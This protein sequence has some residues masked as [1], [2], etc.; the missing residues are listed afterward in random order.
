MKSQNG[1]HS[2]YVQDSYIQYL[3]T[4]TTLNGPTYKEISYQEIGWV[5]LPSPAR[6]WSLVAVPPPACWVESPPSTKIL[7]QFGGGPPS[8][9]A[10]H[11]SDGRYVHF[12]APVVIFNVSPCVFAMLLARCISNVFLVGWGFGDCQ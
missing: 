5:K 12:H 10:T 11:T 8:P 9:S 3:T 2:S 4:N 1:V 6:N 7:G